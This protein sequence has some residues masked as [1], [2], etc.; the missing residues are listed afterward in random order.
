MATN[1]LRLGI[2]SGATRAGFYI[3]MPEDLTGYVQESRRAGRDRF[4]SESIVLLPVDEV[5]D[6]ANQKRRGR[7]IRPYPRPMNSVAY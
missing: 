5:N 4:P 7:V 1:T 6:K 3:T 2:N